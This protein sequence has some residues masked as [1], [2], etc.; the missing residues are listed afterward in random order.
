MMEIQSMEAALTQP[1]PVNHA[2]L[3]ER[4]D[5]AC[6]QV[7]NAFLLF[8]RRT[9]T[10]TFFRLDPVRTNSSLEAPRVHPIQH[11]ID[12]VRCPLFCLAQPR[13]RSRSASWYWRILLGRLPLSFLAEK[14]SRGHAC[15]SR[16]RPD[17]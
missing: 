14:I 4:A 5:T 10:I 13:Y 9:L 8:H 17:L 6:P 1:P 7:T 12:H 2:T 15:Q 16:R 11:A 3:P